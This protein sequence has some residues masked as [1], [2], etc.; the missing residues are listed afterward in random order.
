MHDYNPLPSAASLFSTACLQCT[1]VYLLTIKNSGT[2]GYYYPLML[3]PYAL[4]L[5]FADRLFL[6]RERTLSALVFFNGL[7][8]AAAF[9]SVLLLG[10]MTD[11][12][13]GILAGI[14]CIWLAC[15][16]GQLAQ[17]PPTLFE[18][19]LGTDMALGALALFTAYLSVEELSVSWCVPIAFGCASSIL[20]TIV[21]RSGAG[22]GP[23][24]WVFLGGT[25][26]G[27]L[28]LVWLLVSFV[29]APAGEGLV[30]L[31]NYV[32]KAALLLLRL[33]GKLLLLL[34]SL[35]PE[36]QGGELQS[37]N[38]SNGMGQ[39]EEQ[40][41]DSS[42]LTILLLIILAAGLLVLA[43]L[44]LRALGRIRLSAVRAAKG[45]RIIRRRVSLLSALRRL[46]AGWGQWLSRRIWLWKNRNTAVGLYFLLVQ[47]SGPTPWHKLQGETPRE[48]L[49]RL[50]DRSAGDPELVEALER[51]LPAVDRA[52]FAPYTAE[53]GLFPKAVLVS[54]RLGTAVRR[55]MVRDAVSGLRLRLHSL[56]GASTQH[57]ELR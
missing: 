15:R 6:R 3:L 26:T 43:F 55:G 24:S 14:F 37:P 52:L 35:F 1:I 54:R 13:D 7:L 22:L 57:P 18:L 30:A 32:V 21:F 16:A 4:L 42:I 39:M 53:E 56:R 19:I 20:G 23:R 48:F 12:S 5:F 9:G 25:F 51:L 27:V 31:W 40:M 50:R 44:L 36:G 29:A 41:Q 46:L 45:Q 49:S 38:I 11:F 34:A 33:L 8:C 47:R 2:P 10:G 17:T 28:A